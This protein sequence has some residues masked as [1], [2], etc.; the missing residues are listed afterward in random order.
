MEET[1]ELKIATV[2]PI[3]K[4]IFKDSLTY[5]TSKKVEVGSVVSIPLRKKEALAVVIGIKT[6]EEM[7]IDLKTSEF[8]FKKINRVIGENLFLPDFIQATLDTAEYFASATGQIVR[9]FCPKAI[10]NSWKKTRT[11]KIGKKSQEEPK[12]SY[13]EPLILQLPDEERYPFYKSLIREEFAKKHSIIFVLPTVRDVIDAEEKLKKG[14][15]DYAIFFHGQMSAKAMAEKWQKAIDNPHPI[16]II[17]TPIFLSIPRND[18]AT[19]IVDKEFSEFYKTGNRPFIDIRKFIEF[20][21]RRKQAKLVL[22]DSILRVED[23][24]Q[25]EAGAFT[26]ATSLKFRFPKSL[27]EESLIDMKRGN[28]QKEKSSEETF[29]L[30][31]KLKSEI[32]NAISKK[33]NFVIISARKGLATSTVCSDCGA[34]INCENCLI[35]MVLY[36]KGKQETIFSCNR[37]GQKKS[38]DLKCPIC[39]GWKLKIL[40][41]GTEKT[42]EEIRSTFPNAKVWRLDGE[43]VKSHKAG[44]EMIKSFYENK[45]AILVATEMALGYL[46]ENVDNTAVAS[47]DSLFALPDFQT[48]ENIFNLLMRLKLKTNKRFFIQTRKPEDK[49]FEYV[50]RGDVLE[51]YRKEIRER[52]KW[53]YPPFKTLIKI[54]NSGGEK[55]ANEEMGQLEKFLKKYEP[56]LFSS[57]GKSINGHEEINILI[58]S[59]PTDWPKKAPPA[60]ETAADETVRGLASGSS[61]EYAS[62]L[63]ILLSLPP[64]FIVKINPDSIL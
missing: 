47:I 6:A 59:E 46:W 55:I 9:L 34:I 4:G 10:L 19:I 20:Y 61:E 30:S 52:K 28:D 1:N 32:T 12:N 56:M 53:G 21:A 42:E 5:F 51:F 8:P 37:C 18:L 57:C 64:R 58:K 25:G 35:P 60:P 2:I 48:G 24:Y 26:P 39:S 40:G 63:E 27:L 62:L 29:V 45:G 22:G 14:I 16:I 31:E 23:I 43:S 11:A 13:F 33:E 36:R 54:S 38:S 49:I 7:K 15:E 41:V 44:G 3:E 50:L 17:S